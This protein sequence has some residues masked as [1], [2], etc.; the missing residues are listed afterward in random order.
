MRPL[1]PYFERPAFELFDVPAIPFLGFEGG[2]LTIHGFGILVACGFVVGTW[3]AQ[4][5]ARRDGLDPEAL[6]R[7]VTWWVVGTFVGGHIGHG[8]LYEPAEYL[9]DPRKFLYVWQGLSSFGGFAAVI[10]L[11]IWFFYREKKPFWPYADCAIYGFALGWFLGRMGCFA[12]HDHPGTVTEFWLGVY[13]MCPD[14][15]ITVACHDLGL[16]EAIFTLAVFGLYLILDRK[17]RPAGT[18]VGVYA[19]LYGPVRFLMDFVRHP[20]VDSR[21]MGL[22]PAQYGSILVGLGGVWILY[23]RRGAAPGR[24]AAPPA[25]K[26]E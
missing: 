6:G 5:K 1:I 17:P 21:Y 2:P 3:L 12:A 18:F 7:L 11:T 16:Y 15:P 19:A 20:H 13:G 10:P 4:R 23:S 8:L 25:A 14:R 9:A 24:Q 22:T 26:A